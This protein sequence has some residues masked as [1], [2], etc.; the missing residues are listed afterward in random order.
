MIDAPSQDRLQILERRFHSA[1]RDANFEALER[2][3]DDGFV[4]REVG[5]QQGIERREFLRRAI[6]SEVT[7]PVTEPVWEPVADETPPGH[8]SY[9]WTA[10]DGV[11]YV[12]GSI[13][14]ETEEGLR[15]RVHWAGKGA[16]SGGEPR[17]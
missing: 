10:A 17:S 9:S 7:V 1:I 12:R 5:G 4:A 8:I 16:F 11:S 2:L 14:R 3:L 13:W 15:L 6:Y